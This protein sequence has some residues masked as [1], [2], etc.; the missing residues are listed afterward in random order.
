MGRGEGGGWR[1]E[2]GEREGRDRQT[3]RQTLTDRTAYI[4][5][6]RQTLK[7]KRGRQTDKH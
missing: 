2:R 5:C 6:E 1:G 4:D 7:R 3:G